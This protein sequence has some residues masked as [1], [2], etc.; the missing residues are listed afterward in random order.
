M[1]APLCPSPRGRVYGREYKGKPAGEPGLFKKLARAGAE[2][3][4]LQ[5][6]GRALILD[7]RDD[8]GV[9]DLGLWQE[10]KAH[11]A[12]ARSI[13][14]LPLQ[15]DM[16]V[17]QQPAAVLTGGHPALK[18]VLIGSDIQSAIATLRP[19]EDRGIHPNLPRLPRRAEELQVPA[20]ARP[21]FTGT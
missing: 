8:A 5:H 15:R 14:T 18:A 2:E 1:D 9:A 10:R 16:V 20:R 6:F 11:L 12:L 21:P 13:G 4:G 3:E 7:K 17:P 19:V